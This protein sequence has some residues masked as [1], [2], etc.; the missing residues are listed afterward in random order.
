MA[1]PVQIRLAAEA[2]GDLQFIYSQRLRQRGAHGPD[3][4]DALLDRIYEAVVSLAEFPQRG[5]V[6]PELEAIGM[7]DWRQISVP[8]YRVIYTLADDMLTVGVTADSRRDF[9][10][11]LECRLLQS[12]IRGLR[13][14]RKIDLP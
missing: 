12:P 1:K 7:T 2:E 9:A 14:P 8:L 6:P 13:A 3:V 10:W 4:A 11:L 5:P